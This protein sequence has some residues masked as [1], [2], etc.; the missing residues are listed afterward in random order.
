VRARYYRFEPKVY[1]GVVYGHERIADM[2]PELTVLHQRH[3]EETERQYYDA[4]MRPDMDEVVELEREG[5]IVQFTA[6]AGGEDMVGQLVYRLGRT[7]QQ[8]EKLWATEE[9]FYVVPEA[10]GA[11]AGGIALQLLNY[12]EAA[13]IEMGARMICMA[14]KSPL[15]GPSLSSLARR[16]GYKAV[17]IQYVKTIED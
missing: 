16:R 6:R 1:K 11:K 13:V 9:G 2:L 8:S 3:W 7:Y 10:R 5:I 4:D 14:D 15:G 17:S 12:A